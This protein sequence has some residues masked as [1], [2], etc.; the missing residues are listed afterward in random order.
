MGLVTGFVLFGGGLLDLPISPAGPPVQK[1]KHTHSL[2]L[3]DSYM[4]AMHTE[5]TETCSS[6]HYSGNTV[7][8]HLSKQ[9]PFC[10]LVEEEDHHAYQV[11]FAC[12]RAKFGL[13]G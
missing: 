4:H 6:T 9:Q 3:G 7:D 1:Q 12:S 8:Y 13:I 11:Q 2:P 5:Q 10:L